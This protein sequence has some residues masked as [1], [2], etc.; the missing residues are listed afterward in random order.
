MVHSLWEACG[1][2]Y[3]N[4]S[5]ELRLYL[6]HVHEVNDL[7]TVLEIFNSTYDGPKTPDTHLPKENAK[8]RL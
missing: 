8:V 1:G 6:Y 5:M 3:R 2:T 4:G 7:G